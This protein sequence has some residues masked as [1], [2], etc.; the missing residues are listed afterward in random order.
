[1]DGLSLGWLA[2][3]VSAI[4]QIS[5]GVWVAATTKAKVYGF[6]KRMEKVESKLDTVSERMAELSVLD[7]RTNGQGTRIDELSNRIS[8]VVG[9]LHKVE[10]GPR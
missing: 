8:D 5:A 10:S 1:M 3:G 9:R 2:F 7:E 4:T 6:D